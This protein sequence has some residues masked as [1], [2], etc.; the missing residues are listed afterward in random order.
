LIAKLEALLVSSP[1]LSPS[2]TSSSSSASNR[3]DASTLFDY[4]DSED[5]DT[6]D[7][8]DIE[9]LDLNELVKVTQHVVLESDSQTVPRTAVQ[10][11]ET[12]LDID[13]EDKL[14]RAL[15]FARWSRRGRAGVWESPEGVSDTV[16]D[17]VATLG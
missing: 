9:E 17:L 2:Q 10:R 16:R 15:E 6:D 12:K 7:E 14:E 13:T 8:T 5:D 3:S 1:E 11:V 4:T